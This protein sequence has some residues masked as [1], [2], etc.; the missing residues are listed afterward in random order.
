[1]TELADDEKMDLCEEVD[2][3]EEASKGEDGNWDSELDVQEILEN[4]EPDYDSA[5]TEKHVYMH[6]VET[7]HYVFN[8]DEDEFEVLDTLNSLVALP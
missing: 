8:K 5:V 1:M 6:D 7:V 4:T 2:E 3:G